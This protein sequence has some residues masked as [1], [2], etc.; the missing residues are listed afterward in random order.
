MVDWPIG[1]KI[2]ISTTG[3]RNSEHQNEVFN[4]ESINGTQLTLNGSLKYDHISNVGQYGSIIAEF[5]AEVGLLSRNVIIEGQSAT[6]G[7]FYDLRGNNG[8]HS[9][10]RIHTR[11]H[12]YQL[13]F[14]QNKQPFTY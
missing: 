3:G 14:L 9:L 7:K 13:G 10:K 8:Y 2:V 5:A 1:S 11:V 12:T 4:I 6:K